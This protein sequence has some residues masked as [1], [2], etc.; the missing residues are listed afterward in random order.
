VIRVTA[1]PITGEWL[2]VEPTTLRTTRDAW[3]ARPNTDSLAHDVAEPS[4]VWLQARG[5]RHAIAETSAVLIVWQWDDRSPWQ[6][7]RDAA[8]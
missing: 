3:T 6:W 1:D 4:A 2:D 8:E 5:E 7:D